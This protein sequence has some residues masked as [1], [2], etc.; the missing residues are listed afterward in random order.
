LIPVAVLLGCGGAGIAI[1]RCAFYG[2]GQ[3][4]RRLAGL[5]NGTWPVSAALGL[6]LVLFL[7]GVLNLC[8]VAYP[9]ALAGIIIVGL[10]WTPKMRQVAKVEPCP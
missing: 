9:G 10:S 5:P 1:V 2:W 3:L 8:R 4:T 7:G 6:A